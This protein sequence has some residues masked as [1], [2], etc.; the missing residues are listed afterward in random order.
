[1]AGFQP[2]HIWRFCGRFVKT[3]RRSSRNQSG[4][5]RQFRK[6][7]TEITR[8]SSQDQAEIVLTSF[9]MII[10]RL[11]QHRI[12]SQVLSSDYSHRGTCF[13]CNCW[14]HQ[15]AVSSL[16]RCVRLLPDA[17]SR[18]EAAGWLFQSKQQRKVVHATRLQMKMLQQRGC[19]RRLAETCS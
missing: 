13:W 19:G 8:T 1:M 16:G 6:T 12:G 2:H 9:A 18:P 7:H 15:P 4:T 17:I 10:Q 11:A 14:K 3:L 5:Q